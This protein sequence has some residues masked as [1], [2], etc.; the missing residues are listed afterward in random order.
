MSAMVCEDAASIIASFAEILPGVEWTEKLMSEMHTDLKE[1]VCIDA[2]FGTDTWKANFQVQRLKKPRY[3]GREEFYL[4]ASVQAWKPH[5]LG[6]AGD[7]FSQKF[8]DTPKGLRDAIE[9]VFEKASVMKRRGLCEPCLNGQP[10][11]KKLRLTGLG[12][13]STCL[14]QKKIN[15]V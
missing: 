4:A 10:S 6:G 11:R 5:T 2:K 9:Y 1:Q 13:C 15:I 3:Q 7:V 12:Y 14:V 8:L